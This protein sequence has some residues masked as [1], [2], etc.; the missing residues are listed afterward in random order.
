MPAASPGLLL[1]LASLT[2]RALVA[3]CSGLDTGRFALPL[4]LFAPGRFLP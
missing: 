3:S 4:P 2:D 1:L